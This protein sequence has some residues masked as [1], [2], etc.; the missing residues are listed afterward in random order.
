M[1]RT[2]PLVAYASSSEDD[3]YKSRHEVAE[4]APTNVG[5]S[6]PKKKRKLP[7]LSST[8]SASVPKDNPALHQGRIRT[9]PHVEGQYAAH[10]Y[11][12]VY[13]EQGYRTSE[14]LQKIWCRSK[15]LLPLIHFIGEPQSGADFGIIELHIS[16]SRPIYLRAHQREELK[17]AVRSIARSTNPFPLSFATFSEL[18]NDEKTRTFLT[19]EVGAGHDQLQ[20]LSNA[21]VPTL[22]SFRQKEFYSEPRFHAS[23]AWALMKSGAPSSEGRPISAESAINR[24]TLAA[25]EVAGGSFQTVDSLPETMVPLLKQEFNTALAE[26]SAFQGEYL[27]VRIGKEVSRWRLGGT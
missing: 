17:Q 22:R 26:S 5:K 24:E 4:P 14:V 27:C 16:I 12:P 2:A 11:V 19:L 13:I 9:T 23:I 6:P 21:L 25:T 15:Q 7:G 8:F 3:D 20:K 10:V 18:Q 1:K